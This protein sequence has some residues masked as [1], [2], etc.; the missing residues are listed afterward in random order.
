M[1]VVRRSP[2]PDSARVQQDMEDLFRAL[3]PYRPSAAG[4]RLW[5]PPI[6]VYETKEALVVRA[7]IAGMDE[8]QLQVVVDGTALLIRGMRPDR[9]HDERGCY[10]EA[11]I[12]YG[13]FGADIFIPFLVDPDRATAEYRDGF[14]R[15]VLPRV[16]ARTIIP[17]RAGER[18]RDHTGS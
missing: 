18:E 7:E 5:R 2:R 16:A 15:I 13:A 8:E 12:P 1:Y 3:M 10:H 4:G 9:H 14:L 6:E 17:R 11:H